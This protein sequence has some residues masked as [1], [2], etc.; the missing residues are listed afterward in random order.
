MRR[1]QKIIKI[2]DNPEENLNDTVIRWK[3]GSVMVVGEETGMQFKDRILSFGASR[4]GQPARRY[5]AVN[6]HGLEHSEPIKVLSDI[7]ITIAP[8][9]ILENISK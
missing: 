5:M 3:D 8:E 7:G 9:D 6:V 2:V 4:K 1:L